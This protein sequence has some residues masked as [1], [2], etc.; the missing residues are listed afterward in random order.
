MCTYCTCLPAF[1]DPPAVGKCPSTNSSLSLK[2]TIAFGDLQNGIAGFAKVD[3]KLVIMCLDWTLEVADQVPYEF[4][5]L[6]VSA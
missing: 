5:L 3:A 1:K 6:I 2:V 4:A